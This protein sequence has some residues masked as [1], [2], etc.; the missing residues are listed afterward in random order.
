MPA[1]A[2]ASLW[3]LEDY[4]RRRETFRAE[5][6]AHKLHRR[7]AL[8]QHV[9]LHF[10]DE[11]TIRYQ[12]QEMLRVERIFEDA[13]IQSELE[14]YN[15]LVPDGS[16][17]KATMMIEYP[18]P[19]ERARRLA[20]LRG[21]ERG[22]WLRVGDFPRVQ[23]IADEDLDRE[24]EEKTAAVHFLRFELS[25]DMIAAAKSGAAMAL[26]VEHPAYTAR[27]DPLPEGIRASLVGDFA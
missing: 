1:I 7:V 13:A 19:N 26:G 22:V 8:G 17:L 25:S 20:E 9:T 10:E 12:I 15:P 5:V 24:T 21:I 4:A 3:T 16:N 14:A 6:I 27:L 23:P 18:D 2:R 11:L